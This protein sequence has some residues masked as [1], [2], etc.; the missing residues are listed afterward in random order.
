VAQGAF[1][2]DVRTA[3]EFAAGSLP[4]ATNIPVTE[5]ADRIDEL[6][7]DVPI[8]TYCQSGARAT[9]AANLLRDEGFEVCNLGPISAWDA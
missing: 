4:G 6:P 3:A 2:L 9:T 5:L 8:V 7:T 1:L